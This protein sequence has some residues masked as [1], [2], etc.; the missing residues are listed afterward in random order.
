MLKS[1]TSIIRQ[2]I[3]FY[4][5]TFTGMVSAD[6]EFDVLYDS[7]V[8]F[9]C[10]ASNLTYDSQVITVNGFKSCSVVGSSSDFTKQGP[11][12]AKSLSVIMD[13]KTTTFGVAKMNG[14]LDENSQVIP[15]SSAR[16]QLSLTPQVQ[17]TSNPYNIPENS[18]KV[19]I[20]ESNIYNENHLPGCAGKPSTDPRKCMNSG[21]FGSEVY[22]L[23]L[24]TDLLASDQNK[25]TKYNILGTTSSDMSAVSPSFRKFILSI[26]TTPGDFSPNN[27]A[28]SQL[29]TIDEN[30]LANPGL[31]ELSISVM[32]SLGDENDLAKLNAAADAAIESALN[33]L[34]NVTALDDANRKVSLYYVAKNNFEEARNQRVCLL[35]PDKVYY[36]NVRP[37]NPGCKVDLYGTGTLSSPNGNCRI[38]VYTIQ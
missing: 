30:G 8:K 3:V 37:L 34:T 25:L 21:T 31:G 38:A 26:S 10:S 32:S 6:I 24:K 13:G 28:C 15:P 2:I 11:V 5:L 35:D 27:P 29:G 22:A 17:Q 33:D 7:S 18:G 20:I 16:L 9:V 19:I 4:I 23:K 36:A 12:T 14:L 1:A